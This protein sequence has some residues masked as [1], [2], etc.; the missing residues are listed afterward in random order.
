M[1][2]TERREREQAEEGREKK[3]HNSEYTCMFVE[4]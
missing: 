1:R 2:E 3:T 4:Y